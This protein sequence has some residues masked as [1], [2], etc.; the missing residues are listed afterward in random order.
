MNLEHIIDFAQQLHP[1]SI[2]RDLQTDFLKM[3][4]D[5][6]LSAVVQFLPQFA[7]IVCRDAQLLVNYNAGDGLLLTGALNP[8]L[9]LV[10]QE[11]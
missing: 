1:V 5:T 6:E 2:F 10:Q 4:L 8:G 11:T 7:A 3:F 9:L